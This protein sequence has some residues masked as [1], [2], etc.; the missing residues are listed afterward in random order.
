VRP[1]HAAACP[2]CTVIKTI[3]QSFD[4]SIVPALVP[5]MKNR[6]SG[7]MPVD[8]IGQFRMQGMPA[9]YRA[10]NFFID[11]SD[12]FRHGFFSK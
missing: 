12:G 2:T 10:V 7:P 3:S 1:T 9:Y 4:P 5:A 8:R 11:F 6:A